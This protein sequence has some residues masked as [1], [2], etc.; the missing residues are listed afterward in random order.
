VFGELF[1]FFSYV[2][3]IIFTFSL[4]LSPLFSSFRFSPDGKW[5]ASASKDGQILF[6]DL[7]ASK[8][9]N[10]IRIPPAYFTSFE[11]NPTDF[12]LAGIT[13]S[14]SIKFYDLETMKLSFSTTPES[15]IAK[16]ITY[17]NLG[18]QLFIASKQFFKNL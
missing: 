9:I 2:L 4:L 13:S 14:R 15:Q 8:Y 11:F 12:S 5:V 17:N 16:S 6:Y 18:N 7:I 3:F 10:N 1:P